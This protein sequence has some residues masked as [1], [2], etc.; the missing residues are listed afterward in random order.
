MTKDEAI[1][2]VIEIE[3]IGRIDDERGHSKED[4][5]R[6]DFIR[7]VAEREDELGEI[8]RIVLSTDSFDFARWCA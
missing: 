8:A 3:A 1:Q 2:R 7:F 5:L 4:G 6:S